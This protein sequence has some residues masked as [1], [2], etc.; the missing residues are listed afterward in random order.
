M[1]IVDDPHDYDRWI[2]LAYDA[3]MKRKLWFYETKEG[4]VTFHVQTDVTDI[5][6]ANKE[7]F[8]ASENKRWGDGKVVASIPMGDYYRKIVPAKQ[9]GDDAYVKR[10]LNDPD[11]RAFRTFKGNI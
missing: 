7:A 8:N 9:N 10:W 11:N 2:P 3:E 6:E 1:M 4:K 5:V